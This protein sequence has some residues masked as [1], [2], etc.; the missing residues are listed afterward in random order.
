M[1]AGFIA[2]GKE[3]DFR[4]KDMPNLRLRMILAIARADGERV[5]KLKK[6]KTTELANSVTEKKNEARTS[7]SSSSLDDFLQV[8]EETVV[9]V[10]VA[11]I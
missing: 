7:S 3:L 9:E 8:T 11:N 2:E 10:C 5:E 4:Q 1:V 6:A